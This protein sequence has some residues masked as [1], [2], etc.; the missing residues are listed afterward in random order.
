MLGGLLDQFNFPTILIAIWLHQYNRVFCDIFLRL[1][2]RQHS[3]G[4]QILE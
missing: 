2:F 1:C 4:I 3:S